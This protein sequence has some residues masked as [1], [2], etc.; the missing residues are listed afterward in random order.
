MGAIRY[1]WSE[2]NAR[3]EC[4]SNM[5]IYRMLSRMT[6]YRNGWAAGTKEEKMARRWP[7]PIS[8]YQEGEPQ[9]WRAVA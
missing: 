3:R 9:G 6:S 1:H 8:L 7:K 4:L 2:E 5:K